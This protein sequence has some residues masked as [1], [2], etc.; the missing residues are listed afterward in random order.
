MQGGLLNWPD[1]IDRT[2]EDERESCT[3]FSTNLRKTRSDLS[4]EMDRL[5]AD[6]YRI[7]EVS[8]SGGDPGVVVRWEKGA[9]DYAVACDAYKNKR[10]NLREAYLWVKEMRMQDKRPVSTSQDTYAAA[11]LPSGDTATAQG[12]PPHVRLEVPPDASEAEVRE[13][14]RK[15][16]KEAH[17]DVGGSDEAMKKLTEAKEKMLDGDA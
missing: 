4:D 17:A 12:I 10:N 15:R 6:Q 13:A 5:G 16:A 1:N 9:Q 11:E 14:Y 3:K 2:P 8:G 7:D